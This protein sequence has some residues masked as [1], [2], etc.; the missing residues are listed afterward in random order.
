MLDDLPTK[1][2]LFYVH[3]CSKQLLYIGKGKDIK[4]SVNQLFLRTSKKA[5]ELQKN[6]TSIT[7][8]ETGNE[9]IAQLKFSEEITINKPKYNFSTKI[10]NTIT[11][12]NNENLLIVDKGRNVGEKSVILI[13]NNKIK[14]FCFTD[15]S[16]QVN[17][18]EILKNIIS[19]M[20]DSKINRNI[21]K[22]YLDKNHIEKL[23]RF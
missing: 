16:Y 7:Y 12:F 1:T 9:L 8:E 6:V 13:E 15:L 22:K 4:K 19:P 14:G 23:I 17:N 10:N 3:N 18:L 2:G 5:K 20:D 11:H 21:I